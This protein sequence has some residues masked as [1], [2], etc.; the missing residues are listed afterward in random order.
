[1]LALLAGRVAAIIAR[2]ADMLLRQGMHSCASSAG[3]FHFGCVQ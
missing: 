1:L 3:G 2:L